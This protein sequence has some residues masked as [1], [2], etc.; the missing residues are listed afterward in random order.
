MTPNYTKIGVIF[1]YLA[2]SAGVE[3]AV[4]YKVRL[5]SR[6]LALPIANSPNYTPN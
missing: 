3:P 5:F 6:Q 4:L 1:L 2:V